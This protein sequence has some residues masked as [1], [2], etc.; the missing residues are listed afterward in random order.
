MVARLGLR[1]VE[2]GVA[3]AD[4]LRGER[5]CDAVAARLRF[6]VGVLESSQAYLRPYPLPH[7][8]IRYR[9][10]RPVQAMTGLIGRP[11]PCHDHLRTRPRYRP[12]RPPQ[13]PHP[14]PHAPLQP[15][16]NGRS[17]FTSPFPKIRPF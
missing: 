8:E 9:R 4:F 14:D 1:G 16:L 17:A 6:F 12:P 15:L 2:A 7:L 13:I 3:M 11:R 5:G 10:I